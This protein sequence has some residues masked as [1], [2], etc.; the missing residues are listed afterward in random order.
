MSGLE[1][2]GLAPALIP[3]IG[4]VLKGYARVIHESQDREIY[5]LGTVAP[6][7]DRG[8]SRF[9]TVVQTLLGEALGAEQVS[10]MLRSRDPTVWSDANVQAHINTALGTSTDIFNALC[11]AL[12]ERLSAISN[13]YQVR[14]EIMTR[15]PSD[16][17]PGI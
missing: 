1:V 8:S 9:K 2:M 4:T 12:S 15:Y 16:F 17:H 10:K 3:V 11:G 6:Y 14:Q 5:R 7:L 13:L